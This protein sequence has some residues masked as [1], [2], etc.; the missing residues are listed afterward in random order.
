MMLALSIIVGRWSRPA[1][2]GRIP[3]PRRIDRRFGGSLRGGKIDEAGSGR[4]V[5][6]DGVRLR[7]RSETIDAY[8][9]K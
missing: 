6:H 3:P 7:G 8:A 2:A 1:A 9:Y 5:R 4:W